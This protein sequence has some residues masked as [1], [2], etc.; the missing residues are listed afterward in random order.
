MMGL[1]DPGA[2]VGFQSMNAAV[3][4]AADQG[5]DVGGDLYDG[6]IER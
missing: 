2:D 1:G 3:A 4:A 5:M 6:G